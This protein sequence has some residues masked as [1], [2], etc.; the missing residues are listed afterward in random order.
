[1]TFADVVAVAALPFKAAATVGTVNTLVF[2]LYLK[3]VSL[4]VAS[5]D[6]EDNGVN[7]I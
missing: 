7:V 4:E 5:P 3:S 2:G 1:M 6:P